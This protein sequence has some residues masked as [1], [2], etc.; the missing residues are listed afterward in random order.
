MFDLTHNH[1]WIHLVKI[2]DYSIGEG[3]FPSDAGK[4]RRGKAKEGANKKFSLPR[5]GSVIPS[6]RHLGPGPPGTFIL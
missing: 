4:S 6:A 1:G 3:S 5:L 2:E